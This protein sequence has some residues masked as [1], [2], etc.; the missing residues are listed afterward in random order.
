[1]SIWSKQLLL[2]YWAYFYWSQ[3]SNRRESMLLRFTSPLNVKN[4]VALSSI[5]VEILHSTWKYNYCVFNY[6]NTLSYIALISPP[7]SHIFWGK[8]MPF[9]LWIASYPM[10]ACNS[11]W[12]A[13]T[14][15]NQNKTIGSDL[16]PRNVNH[17]RSL[18]FCCYVADDLNVQTC[19]KRDTFKITSCRYGPCHD[20]GI[21]VKVLN[22]A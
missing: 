14:K 21:D 10:G 20:I 3:P 11:I 15:G 4:V 7:P 2:H 12:E 18:P 1:M 5:K 22:I 6:K 8:L 13:H 9:I 17:Q 16:S 19:F